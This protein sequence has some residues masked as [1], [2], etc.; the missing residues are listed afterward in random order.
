MEY[1]GPD[2]PYQTLFSTKDPSYENKLETNADLRA[3]L[4]QFDLPTKSFFEIPTADGVQTMNGF[5]VYP[6]YFNQSSKYPVLMNVYGGPG[7]QYVHTRFDQT[8]FTTYVASQLGYIVATV[9]G[10]GTGGKSN[11]FKKQV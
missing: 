4:A 7:S 8:G 9:D 2:I 3:N 10:R 6:P 1:S 5:A 11:T